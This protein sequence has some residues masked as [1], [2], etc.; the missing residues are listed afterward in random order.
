MEEEAEAGTVETAPEEG[1]REPAEGELR[2]VAELQTR[3]TADKRHHEAAFKQMRSDMD[4]ARTGAAQ[5]WAEAGNYVANIV[6]RHVKMKTASLYA[7][8]PKAIARRAERLDFA[9]WDE[10]T[11]SLLE[12]MQIATMATAQPPDP[13]TG[14]NMA[15]MD[16]QVQQA[17]AVVKDYSDG[18]AERDRIERIGKTLEILFGYFTREQTPLDFKSQMKA[19]V[20]RACTTGVGYLKIGFQ[21]EYEQDPKVVESLADFTNQLRHV[22]TL[23]EKAQDSA[24]AD[25]EA[26][27]E[28]LAQAIK[29]MQEREYVLLREGLIFDFPESTNVIPDKMCRALTGFLGARHITV[30]YLYTCDEVKEIFGVKLHDSD[31]TRLDADGTEHAPGEMTGPTDGMVR[32]WEHYDRA[33]GTVYYLADGYKQYLRAPQAP[34]IYVEDFWPVYPLTFNEVE[35]HKQLFPP[36][37]VKL[38]EHQQHEYNRAKQGIREHRQFARPRAFGK[39]G[40]VDDEDK[41]RI[42]RA[43]PF[44]YTELNMAEDGDVRQ[45]L[46][47][48]EVPGVDPNLY[49]TGTTMQDVQLVLGAQE[50]SFGGV[51]KATATEAALADGSQMASESSA[52]DEL[53]SFL[54][55]VAKASGQVLLREMAEESVKEIVGPGAV[56]PTMT[57]D[58][59]VRD[60]FLEIEAGSSGRPNQAAEIK[61]W[62]EML[63]FLIQ[64]PRINPEWLA[65]ESLRRLDDRMDLTDALAEGIPSIVQ[66]NAAQQ[67]GPEDP[68]NAPAAQGDEG[69]GQTPNGPEATEG[70]D[71]PMGN[72]RV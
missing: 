48:A 44:T 45:L 71:A 56:W 22:E 52:V 14:M 3:I 20:R 40:L 15:M 51:S 12:A 29:S 59:V 16:L 35:H 37:D 66:M 38:I 60:L 25:F 54:T 21:R 1:A 2:L 6:G 32:V 65:R 24:A 9:V 63:P 67:P 43:E 42:A 17:I 41:T 4:L 58:Q 27:R 64:M 8:N 7:K 28:E 69:G 19:L 55:R 49:E 18:M 50:A 57:L 33:A 34:D 39:T 62:R 11:E 5:N 68:A 72:N 47:F 13:M 30:E 53:D 46:Q 26:R 36:S 70:T 61:N 23:M 10:Q 31:Y